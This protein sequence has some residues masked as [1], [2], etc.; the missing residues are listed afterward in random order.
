MSDRT[1]WCD[2]CECYQE[3]IE[4]ANAKS[5]PLECGKCGSTEDELKS[6]YHA[7]E[8]NWKLEESK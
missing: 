2:Y 7:D 1:T 6:S 4:D 3:C 5:P 8:K